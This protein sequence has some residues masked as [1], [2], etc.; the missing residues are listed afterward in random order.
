MT[1]LLTKATNR[2]IILLLFTI[3]LAWKNFMPGGERLY[4]KKIFKLLQKNNDENGRVLILEAMTD[5]CVFIL[6]N[7]YNPNTE[8]EQAS[9]WKKR[10]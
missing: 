6:V 2:G 7:L 5:D 10:I 8:K 3:F 4:W 9:T 1:L